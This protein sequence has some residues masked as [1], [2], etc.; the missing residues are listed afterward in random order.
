MTKQKQSVIDIE[1]KPFV[2]W[3]G[4]KRQLISELLENKPT[5]FDRYFE[6]FVGA[7]ALFFELSYEPSILVDINTDLINA[8]K[9]IKHSVDKLIDLLKIHKQN[10]SEEYFYKVRGIWTRKCKELGL[11]ESDLLNVNDLNEIELAARFIFLNRTCYN[12]LYRKNS[13]GEFNV[14]FGD[15][16]NPKICDEENL[17]AV[18]KLLS[19]ATII[20][21]HFTI[22]KNE[23]S[24]GKG[25]FIY[26]DPPYVPLSETSDFTSYTKNGFD[27]KAQKRLVSLFEFVDSQGGYCMLTNSDTKFVRENYSGY[28]INV[29]KAKRAI[30]CKGSKR[31]EINE[32]IITNY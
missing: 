31:G 14:P 28:N 21:D 11:E 2:K 16:K 15:Y 18:S 26:F 20:N 19:K 1:A 6:P 25:D 4:G 22:I 29:V 13:S 32:L 5:D 17:L 10:H 12:G 23:F 7:G 3:A 8:Y 27:E 9:V 30:N 24:I